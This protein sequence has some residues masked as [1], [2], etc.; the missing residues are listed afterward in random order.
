MKT[1]AAGR[2]F[3]EAFEGLSLRAYW[4]RT[5]RVFTIGYGHTNAAGPPRVTS[6]MVIT[7]DVADQILAADLASVEIEVEHYIKVPLT[8]FQFDPLIS[9]QFNTGWLGKPTCSLTKA[10]NS[11]NTQLADEDFMLYDRS[12]GEVLPGLI[13]RR[14]GEAVMFAGNVQEALQIA[15]AGALAA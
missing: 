5:G 8:Q 2:A 7:K 14:H 11:G 12:G 4:D 1:S 9:F 15:G 10:V 6:G 3:I 13:R